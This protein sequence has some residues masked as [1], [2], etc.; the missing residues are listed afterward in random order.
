M[1]SVSIPSARAHAVGS[2]RSKAAAEQNDLAGSAVPK[3]IA[4]N[5]GRPVLAQSLAQARAAA[6]SDFGGKVEAQGF[7]NSRLYQ[8]K[9]LPIHGLAN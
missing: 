7:T 1:C 2:S 3:A 5:Q 9:A 4:V 8:F 6:S